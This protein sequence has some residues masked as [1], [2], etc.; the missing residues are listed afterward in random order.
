LLN[1]SCIKEPISPSINDNIN[2]ATSY[3]LIFCEG[4]YGL[5]NA[6]ISFIN[7]ETG[8]INNNFFE[9]FNNFQIGDVL[10][11]AIIHKEYLY[12]VVSTSKTIYKISLMT[13][14][15][16]KKLTFS[17]NNLPRKI[18]IYN[19]STIFVTDAYSNSVF[20]INSNQMNINYQIKVG[21]QP[22]GISIYNN[23][24]FTA[25]SG[26]GDINKTSPD[27]ST[28][29][30]IDLNIHQEI[31][32]IKTKNNPVELLI[33]SVNN[34]LYVVY[35]NYP[36]LKDSSGGILQYDIHSL[37]I[38]KEWQG[39]YSNLAL[40]Y[41][42]DTLFMIANNTPGK[43]ANENSSIRMIDR[44][45][46]LKKEIIIKK[47]TDFWYSFFIDYSRNFIWVG[48]AK[49]FQSNGEILIFSTDFH[50]TTSNYIKKF[51]VNV[52]PNK[53]ILLNN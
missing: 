11:D 51:Q 19:D 40:S 30:I 20:E 42:K 23:L 1:T 25:N 28:I 26:W 29:S 12:V 37:Q 31:S 50:N 33:D 6:S 22:E 24:L 44:K 4:N 32:K 9:A 17:G 2:L 39:N 45:T 8:E 47:S 35:Y 13:G 53:I 34:F 41:T 21:A 14:K 15:V 49:N 7:L 38:L 18:A 10:N 43:D 3:A 52:N 48:N 5:N 16:V 46:D 27:A 36:S